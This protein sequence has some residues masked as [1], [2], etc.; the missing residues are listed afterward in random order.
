M[1]VK[2]IDTVVLRVYDFLLVSNSNHMSISIAVICIKHHLEDGTNIGNE[3]DWLNS[4]FYI[5]S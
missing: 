2:S 4:F 1:K 3:V 5:F